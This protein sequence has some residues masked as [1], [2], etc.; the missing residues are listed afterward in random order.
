[1][2]QAAEIIGEY[3]PFPGTERVNGVTF[4]GQHVWFASGDSLRAFDPEKGDVVR[5]IDV[6]SHAGTAFDGRHLYELADD[7]IQKVDPETACVHSIR[8]RVMWCA[9]SMSRRTR[10]PHLTDG[11]CIS[12]LM[13]G[14]RRSIRRQDAWSQRFRRLRVADLEWRGPKERCGS[15]SIA[16]GKSIRL[17]RRRDRY[18]ERSNPTVS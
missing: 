2:T 7:R 1:M 18:C 3:G 14:F 13:I 11:T 10:E 8:R 4:D 9:R 17:I 6:A 5:S 12:S 16:H 15:D